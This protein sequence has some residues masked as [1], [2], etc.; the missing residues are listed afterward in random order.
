MTDRKTIDERLDVARTVGLVAELRASVPVLG[1]SADGRAA[2]R[3]R[4]GR[5]LDD[6]VTATTRLADV[7]A[8]RADEVRSKLDALQEKRTALGEPDAAHAFD[9]A[10]VQIRTLIDRTTDGDVAAFAKLIAGR[11]ATAATQLRTEMEGKDEQ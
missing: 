11:V 1:G 3:E 8:G 6:Y 7:L 9:N 10:M 5:T 4:L 2:A